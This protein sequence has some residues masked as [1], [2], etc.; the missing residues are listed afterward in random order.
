MDRIEM[1]D[2]CKRIL[3]KKINRM[4]KLKTAKFK[5][6]KCAYRQ[7]SNVF[8]LFNV[9]KVRNQMVIITGAPK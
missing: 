4:P 3:L 9:V 7:Y 6:I 2:A 8:G 5:D 1:S